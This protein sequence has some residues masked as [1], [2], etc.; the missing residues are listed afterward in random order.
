[1]SNL[2]VFGIKS[3]SWCKMYRCFVLKLL[4]QQDLPTFFNQILNDRSVN[5]PLKCLSDELKL[6]LQW[7]NSFKTLSDYNFV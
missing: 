4:H 7:T 6:T 3:V 2:S 5:C 1:M